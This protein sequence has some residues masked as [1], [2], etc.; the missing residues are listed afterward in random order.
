VEMICFG[1][2]FE[3]S[4]PDC[5]SGDCMLEMSVPNRNL[6][7]VGP[8]LQLRPYVQESCLLQISAKKGPRVE[9]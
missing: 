6:H 9:E 1:P 2:P 4:R 3:P 7:Q 5:S 8:N